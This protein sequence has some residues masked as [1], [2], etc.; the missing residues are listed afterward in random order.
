MH[1]RL[2]IGTPGRSDHT[3]THPYS[4]GQY[5]PIHELKRHENLK[6]IYSI[7]N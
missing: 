5:I 3:S 7:R 2:P 4:Q 6:F 1:C